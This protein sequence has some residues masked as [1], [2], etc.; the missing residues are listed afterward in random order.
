MLF[1]LVSIFIA[2]PFIF[3]SNAIFFL[4]SKYLSNK[5]VVEAHT[6]LWK[7]KFIFFM[8]IF[9][10]GGGRLVKEEILENKIIFQIGTL[11]HCWWGYKMVQ[12][13]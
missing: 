12:P 2:I 9:L 3:S 8:I 1:K 4:D 6:G 13:L 5:P 10:K 7:I 11:N